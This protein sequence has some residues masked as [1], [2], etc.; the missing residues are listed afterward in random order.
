MT[1]YA[2]LL[3]R[4]VDDLAR[5]G[6]PD[7]RLDAEILLAEA[8]SLSRA[9]VRARLDDAPDDAAAG[10]FAALIARRAQHEPV[11]YILGR[12]AFYGL[13]FAVDRRVLIPRPETEL[14]VECALAWLAAR[15][16]ATVLDVGT[17]SGAIAVALAV[18]APS[19]RV[20]ALDLSPDALAV[21]QANAARHG[22]AAR[23][24]FRQSDLLESAPARADLMAA[25]LPY[26]SPAEWPALAPGI[27]NYEPHRALDGGAEGLDLFRRFFAQAP[28]HLAP[29]GALMLEIGW[30]QAR[31]VSALA[32]AA[33]RAAT[34]NVRRDGADLDRLVI[35]QT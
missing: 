28:A 18:H 26:I 4:A 21:A 29:G 35:V 24:T 10:R 25:N 34:I 7:A 22:V 13:D 3:R 14:L 27:L 2:D 23:I 12:Q 17:G 11:A 31:A 9:S 5:A 16:T 8:R 1:A 30:T 6:I 33:F 20:V 15:T 32:Q 19:I